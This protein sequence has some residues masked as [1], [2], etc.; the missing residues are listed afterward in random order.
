[1]NNTFAT[2]E[3]LFKH[4]KENKSILIAEKKSVMKKADAFSYV[5]KNEVAKGIAN[6][7]N[8][9]TTSLI[10][11]DVLR[12]KV[13]INTTNLLDSHSDVHIKSLWKKTLKEKKDIFLLQ[14]HTMKFDH[15]IADNVNASVKT[16]KWSDL[17]YDFEGETEALLFEV[18]VHK[19]RNP[20]MFTQYAK[21]YVKQHS[22]GMIY[23]TLFLC[24]NSTDKYYA[25]EKENWDKYI[26]EV[27]NKR[28]AEELGYFWAV[29]EAK[30]VEGSAVVL[31]SN[32]ATPTISVKNINEPLED[33]QNDNNDSRSNDTIKA[34]YLKSFILQQLKK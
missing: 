10:D 33:T 1:M 34:E 13:V 29:T 27:A 7:E 25:E 28:D 22:V 6:K 8:A 5:S 4:L 14:E 30:L 9:P 15:I 21:G 11:K 18:D 31:G 26:S 12:V 2:K 16:Y 3:E 23:V 20:F 19:E 24:I 32:Y 17:D